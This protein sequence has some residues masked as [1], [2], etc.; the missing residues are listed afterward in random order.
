MS[1]NP[2]VST[3]LIFLN[4]EQFIEEAIDSV[5]A[6]T[7]DNWELLLVDDG[8]TD[9]STEIA[10]RY[11]RQHPSKV[12]YLEHEHHQNRGMSASRNLGIRYAQGDY[13]ALLD[14]DDIWLP[15]KLEEQMA[16]LEAH[17]N[18]GMVCGASQYW[19]SWTADP[20]SHDITVA[21]GAPPDTLV[22]PPDLL[23]H[24][25]PLGEGNAPCPSSL[26]FRRAVAEKVGG[27]EEGFRDKYQL[28]EDQAFLN[29]VY[30][31]TP[32]FVASAC[33]DRYR[34]H[35]GSCVS[36]VT[37]AGQY[38][39]VRRFFLNWFETYMA[40][41]GF[42]GTNTWEALQK[43]LWPYRHPFLSRIVALFRHPAREVKA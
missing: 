19:R 6:Q 38:H 23:M 17:S 9:A 2:L 26:L 41:K 1:K 14:A 24:L 37:R 3:V 40:G 27:F 32:V 15:H 20:D 35:P 13:I 33:W 42:Q 7:Y 28:Y 25:Y 10:Q 8:S 36:T 43:A 29:K 21:V 5:F 34:Q 11:A 16:I 39:A 12:Y 22:P 30:L 18:A 4:E 31:Q